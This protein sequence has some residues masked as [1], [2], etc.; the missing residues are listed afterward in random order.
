MRRRGCGAGRFRASYRAHLG[1][2]QYFRSGRQGEDYGQKEDS[3]Y[4]EQADFILYNNGDYDELYLQ[5]DIALS[6]IL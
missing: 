6:L 3:F 2:G 1:A 4:S 5:A